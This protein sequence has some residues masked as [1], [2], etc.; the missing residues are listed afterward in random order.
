MGNKY[1]VRIEIGQYEFV[2]VEKDTAEDAKLAYNEIKTV[3]G[4]NVPQTELDTLRDKDFNEI[5]DAQLTG[6]LKV[7]QYEALQK[8]TPTQR[9]VADV[10]KRALAR[11]K[12]KEERK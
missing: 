5:I 6:K 12:A 9:A 8:M 3:F 4:R 7:D 2:E 10:I 11:L 1:K